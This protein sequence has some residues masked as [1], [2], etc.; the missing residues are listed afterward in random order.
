MQKCVAVAPV[1]SAPSAS[2]VAPPAHPETPVSA[3]ARV[4]PESLC[5]LCDLRQEDEA[6]S[7]AGTQNDVILP[8]FM[9]RLNDHFVNGASLTKEGQLRQ[10]LRETMPVLISGLGEVRALQLLA[11][12]AYIAQHCPSGWKQ[13]G[14]SFVSSQISLRAWK[15]AV[16]RSAWELVRTEADPQVGGKMLQ[17]LLM[18]RPGADVQYAQAMIL[19]WLRPKAAGGCVCAL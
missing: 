19:G 18:S 1:A 4:P 8:F 15:L 5:H 6:N 10:G 14:S 16:L 12:A 2:E 13:A 11:S 7:V 17:E 3:A 9:L